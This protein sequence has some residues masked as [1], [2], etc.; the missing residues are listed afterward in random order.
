MGLNLIVHRAS[1]PG[2][3]VDLTVRAPSASAL[4]SAGSQGPQGTGSRQVLQVAV[5]TIVSAQRTFTS[6]QAL[7]RLVGEKMG[8]EAKLFLRPSYAQVRQALERAAVDV[9]FVCTGTYVYARDGGRIELLAQPQFREGLFYRSLLLVPSGSS[10]RGLEDLR[11]ATVAFSDPESNTGR[12][13]PLAALL[14]AGYQPDEFLGKVVFSGSHD[15]SVGAVAAGV[16]DAAAVD[17]LVFRS[18][19]EA[20]PRLAQ[21]VRV[22]W[23]SE[24]F[25]PPPVVVPTALDPALKARLREVILNLHRDPAARVSLGELGIVRFVEPREEDYESA[26]RVFTTVRSMLAPGAR[27][28]GQGR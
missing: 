18:L 16:V 27:P 17:A 15:R 20:D 7:V 12:L 4:R 9:A 23:E 6:Y 5:A 21:R 25:G 22:V 13:V 8:L 14:R 24:V 11:G 10:I 28:G 26:Y 2:P 3:F 19:L 1:P